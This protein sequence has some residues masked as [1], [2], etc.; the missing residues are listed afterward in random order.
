MKNK[1]ALVKRLGVLAILLFCLGYVSFSPN[2]QIVLAY[3]CCESC[4]IPPPGD[5]DYTPSEYCA[6]QCGV[7]SGTCYNNCLSEVYNCWQ[8]CVPCGGGGGNCGAC[9][10]GND[11]LTGVCSGG[12]CTCP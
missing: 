1:L 6:D 9:V 10:T 8:W 4:P 7:R 12:H 5:A 2:S 11:C 3:P